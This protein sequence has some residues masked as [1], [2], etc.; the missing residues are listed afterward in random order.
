M[1]S[2]SYE[3]TV[4]T[5]RTIEPNM[6]IDE[7]HY[8]SCSK[9]ADLIVTMNDRIKELEVLLKNANRQIQLIDEE[10]DCLNHILNLI[11]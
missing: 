9:A 2:I 1:V 10:S 4:N 6:V 7:E 5:L 8:F 11:K 3:E